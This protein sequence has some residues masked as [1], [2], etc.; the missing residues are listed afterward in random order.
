MTR[1]FEALS[2]SA[3]TGYA[4]LFDAAQA[5]ELARSVE[6]LSGSF[7]SKQV[8]GNRYWYFQHT[9]VSGRLRQI[10]VGPDNARTR[11]LVTEHAAKASTPGIQ[12]LINSAAALG[13]EPVLLTHFRVIRRL[14]D[15]GFFNAG[16]VLV[17]T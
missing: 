1:P 16:G 11:E 2:L 8:K 13:C 17:G 3:Q 15:Y 12:P 6:S 9:D 7:A 5:A 14:A 4:Q 10:Y